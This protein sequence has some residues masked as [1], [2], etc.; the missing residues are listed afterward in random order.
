MAFKTN[1]PPL[2]GFPGGK[3][4]LIGSSGYGRLALQTILGA[5]FAFL[6]DTEFR[7][8]ILVMFP[9]IQSTYLAASGMALGTQHA[10]RYHNTC[11]REAGYA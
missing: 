5:L 10:C 11:A 1:W 3:T 8:A 9:S 7:R 2:S 6:F 4:V